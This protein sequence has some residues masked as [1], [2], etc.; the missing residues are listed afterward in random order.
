[1]P[2]RNLIPLALLAVLALLTILFAVLGASS[3]PSGA[4]LAVQNAS[5]K[6]FGSPTGSTSFVMD[7]VD[8]ASAG[9]G[10]GTLSQVRQIDYVPPNRMVVYQV[11]STVR[12]LAVLDQ[13]AI[14]CTLSAYTTLVGGSTP[15]TASG[16]A[17]TRTESLADY[18]ARVP[19]VTPTSCAPR[20]ATVHGQVQERAVIR[21]GYLVGVRLTVV[22]PPQTLPGGGSAAHGVEGEAVVMVQING[23]RVR[24]L[25]S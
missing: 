5:G 7:L 8:T 17:Y 22:V 15:W 3:A 4:T 24:S 12:R 1:M 9:A 20:P 10:T 13:A 6:T 21:S 2:R 11:G 25:G 14:T 19:Q 16:D 18:S 23:T